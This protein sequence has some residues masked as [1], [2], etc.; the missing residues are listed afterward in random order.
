MKLDDKLEYYLGNMDDEKIK[1]EALSFADELRKKGNILFII[2]IILTSLSFIVFL[3][4]TIIFIINKTFSLYQ[5]IPFTLMIIFSVLLYLG[6]LY[7][8]YAQMLKE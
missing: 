5:I 7:K 3:V 8:R 2:G 4:L 1:K 6:L